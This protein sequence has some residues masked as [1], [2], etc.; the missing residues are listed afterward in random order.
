[1]YHCDI[2]MTRLWS[3]LTLKMPCSTLVDMKI[4]RNGDAMRGGIG[5]KKYQ[6][7]GNVATLSKMS[8]P[9]KKKFD[10]VKFGTARN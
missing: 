9:M 5:K 1:M 7:V 10:F 8:G 3:M 4:S 6:R 2:L